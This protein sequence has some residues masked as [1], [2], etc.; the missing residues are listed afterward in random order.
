MSG[1]AQVLRESGITSYRG[2]ERHWIYE[3]DS[4]K[5]QRMLLRQGMRLLDSYVQLSADSV[6][7][8][9]D[10][11]QPDGLCNIPSSR[12]L[13][14]YSKRLAPLEPLRL[15]RILDVIGKAARANSIVHLNWRLHDFG[16]NLEENLRVLRSILE[17][18]A[19][20]R[21]SH[22]MRALSMSEVVEALRGKAVATHV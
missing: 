17:C 3:G 8:W 18:Y 14:P 15:K 5:S 2:A 22:G 12:I 10:V 4:G 9:R 1:Y 19:R 16:V 13:R 6:T 20:Q 7:R 11:P 21:D